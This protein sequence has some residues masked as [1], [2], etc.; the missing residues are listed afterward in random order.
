M[1][2]REICQ[3]V[4]LH[5][6]AER[7]G[8]ERPGGQAGNYRS[9]HHKDQTPSISVFR[10]K[11]CPRWKDHSGDDRDGGDAIDLVRYVQGCGTGEAARW[12]RDEFGFPCEPQQPAAPR[13]LTRA[14]Y[15]ARRCQGGTD[16]A[17][18]YL[19]GRAITED[20][21]RRAVEAGS[22]GFNDWASPTRPEGEVGH[23]GPAV[24]FIVRSTNPGDV[25]AVDLRYVDPAANGGSKTQTQGEKKG[26]GWT[27]DYRTIEQART[28][29]VVESPINALSVESCGLKRVA[30]VAT[31]GTGNVTAIDWSM[32]EGKRVLI[33]LDNDDPDD[34]GR[35]PGPEASWALYEEL[36]ARDIACHLV[37]QSDWQVNDVNDLLQALGPQEAGFAL[38]RLEPWAIPGVP[39]SEDKRR[40][41]ARVWMPAHD[42]AQYWRFRP[43]EDFTTYVDEKKP[44]KDGLVH[45]KIVDLAAFRIAQ[46]S[47][48]TIASARATMTGEKDAQ[49]TTVFCVSVQ[50]ARHEN[51]L[52]RR[53][54][55][56]ED[57]HNINKW[58]KFATVWLPGPFLR[59]VNILERGTH[60][61][62]QQAVNYV[63]LCWLGG[64]LRV[65]E[66]PDCYFTEPEKQCPYHNLT[67]PSG[68]RADAR[69]V[70]SAYQNTFGRNAATLLLMWSLGGHLKALLGFWPHMVLQAD[71]GAGKSSLVKRLERSI[72]FTMF[73]GQSLQTEF[74]LLTSI[75]HTSHPVGW[76]EIS[77]RK[78]EII[79]RAVAILQESYQFTTTRRGADLTE[80]LNSAPVLLA[81]EDVPVR[82]LLGKVVR[83]SLSVAG[84]GAT[85]PEDLPQF[86]VRQ[87]LE[88]LAK[89]QTRGHVTQLH[90]RATERMLAVS[91]AS[92]T[93]PGAERMAGNYAAVLASWWLLCEFA[94]LDAEAG[95][96]EEDLV[97]E[98][99]GHI[100]DTSG[101]R[102]PWVWILEHILGEISAGN[103]KHPYAIRRID[104]AHECLLLR[105]QHVMH[106]LRSTP[107]MRDTWN[108]L[109]V[110]TP[111]VFARQLK[112]A[113]VLY[114]ERTDVTIDHR[115]EFHMVA[116]SIEAMEQYGLYVSM[117][118]QIENADRWTGPR[119]V[120][121]GG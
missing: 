118:E 76:E 91:R 2:L 46:L 101:D 37:D 58:G 105:P 18:A 71:K 26:A 4:D 88:Y 68:T 64:K 92:G 66:G 50:Q 117:P 27:S 22:V 81:G 111:A 7:L 38:Q 80:F 77:S 1:E 97:R 115:R 6:V 21:V 3:R 67:F 86:P 49:P 112:T 84:Q 72:A 24:A 9:P 13:E 29:Y 60:L 56:D 8:L 10:G 47:R 57:V 48:R 113:D 90:A 33:C 54:F 16:Q 93:D 19:T 75:G 35:R 107:G 23:G 28:V 94:G 14:E 44:D 79:D 89:R 99:N 62:A 109:P 5:V 119:A 34:R 40:G 17:V 114:R 104:D 32:L 116:I 43:K 96:F 106:H 82:S 103:Y 110:K 78:Q 31:R 69:Q 87:W 70:V 100:A 102:S 36:T 25:L 11:D 52:V 85:I 55:S 45:E 74:R 30:A 15:I 12:L 83:T 39:S 59:L 42:Y 121:A 120:G 41:K 53:V 63:G 61:G 20:V 108:A 65:N 98:M 51:K 73:S 95:D